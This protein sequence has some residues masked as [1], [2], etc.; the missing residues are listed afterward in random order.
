M[1]DWPATVSFAQIPDLIGGKINDAF[2]PERQL[3]LETVDL[4]EVRAGEDWYFIGPTSAAEF[5]A[6]P[7]PDEPPDFPG[8]AGLETALRDGRPVPPVVLERTASGQLVF[9]DGW[10]RMKIALHVGI[11]H[12]PAYIATSLPES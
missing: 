5:D 4:R 8:Y 3:V 2:E 12:M 9:V 7:D 1:T 6:E 10:H 11:T